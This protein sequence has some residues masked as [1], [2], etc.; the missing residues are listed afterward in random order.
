MIAARRQRGVAVI[1]AILLVAIATMIAVEML[2]R[3]QLDQR[4]T[5]ALIQSEQ[6][7]LYLRG[8]EAL[9]G[10]ILR[11]DLLEFGPDSDHLGEIWAQRLD[12]LPVEGGYVAGALED[13]QGR[14]NLNNLINM[15]GQADPVA[16][17]WFQRL[18]RVLEL[19]PE[20]AGYVVDWLDIDTQPS[21]PT[22]AEDGVYMSREPPYRP[23][24]LPIT[25]I[26]ELLAIEGI[27]PDIFATLRPFVAALPQGTALNVNTASAELLGSLDDG[28]GLS[29][30]LQLIEQRGD[31]D[32]PDFTGTFATLV[33][34][35]ILPRLDERSSYFRLIAR[36]AIGSTQL[37]MYSV[38]YREPNGVVRPLLRSLGTE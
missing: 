23:P 27:D 21:F 24:N 7:W 33:D 30:A 38:L 9:A 25:S 20:L 16:V 13:L 29:S 31:Q 15:S 37:T 14:F 36:A 28:L 1:T 19:D 8:A 10:D 32:F 2:W 18:L 26:S 17:E 35:N 4:R 5:A 12:P 34:A 11:Q 6:A 22:G 3:S